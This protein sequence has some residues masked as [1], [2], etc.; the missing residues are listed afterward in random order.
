MS[1]EKVYT[2]QSDRIPSRSMRRVSSTME[3]VG[4][5]AKRKLCPEFVDIT[6]GH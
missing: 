2:S 1:R 6:T 4:A 3:I 5:G